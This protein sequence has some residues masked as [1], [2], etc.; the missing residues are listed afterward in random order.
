M[1]SRP[2]FFGSIWEWNYWRTDAKAKDTTFG[3]GAQHQL[4]GFTRNVSLFTQPAVWHDCDLSD[5]LLQHT[6][7]EYCKV[8]VTNNPF[9]LMLCWWW[10]SVV[11]SSRCLF[12]NCPICWEKVVCFSSSWGYLFCK[13]M[14]VHGISNYIFI[15][16]SPKC[17]DVCSS[18]FGPLN[19]MVLCCVSILLSRLKVELHI[20]SSKWGT[21]NKH[22]K[23]VKWRHACEKQT[24]WLM[25]GSLN[26]LSKRM[27][28]QHSAQCH[29]KN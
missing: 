10:C 17:T 27:H 19:F 4:R 12:W 1:L 5:A 15:V 18:E 26:H 2:V 23:R 21:D 24:W 16:V 9:S 25:P 3:D 13:K 11:M 14:L 7:Q 20:T 22:S 6:Q 8:Y 29:L 28:S